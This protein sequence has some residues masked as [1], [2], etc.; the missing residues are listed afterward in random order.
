M[1]AILKIDNTV[2]F[3]PGKVKKHRIENIRLIFQCIIMVDI[4]V[5]LFEEAYGQVHRL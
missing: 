2:A 4:K 1:A 3:Q 5:S